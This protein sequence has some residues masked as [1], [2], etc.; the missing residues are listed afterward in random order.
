MFKITEVTNSKIT[1]EN[2]MVG[3]VS[4]AGIL[5]VEFKTNLIDFNK[6][7]ESGMIEGKYVFG[8]RFDNDVAWEDILLEWPTSL[9]DYMKYLEMYQT[10][11]DTITTLFIPNALME[12]INV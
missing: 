5:S 2:G 10:I 11:G 3:L 6:C 12:V 7:S 8:F 9:G 4:K 1:W